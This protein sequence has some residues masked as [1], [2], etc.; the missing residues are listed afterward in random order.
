MALNKALAELSVWR[1]SFSNYSLKDESNSWISDYYPTL[2]LSST[3]SCYTCLRPKGKRFSLIIQCIFSFNI[4]I[5]NFCHLRYK[6]ALPQRIRRIRCIKIESLEVN[7]YLQMYC[8][9]LDRQHFWTYRKT[10]IHSKPY[11]R[12]HDYGGHFGIRSSIVDIPTKYYSLMLLNSLRAASKDGLVSCPSKL[13]H[14]IFY[15]I[16]NSLLSFFSFCRHLFSIF[17]L[18]F[19]GPRS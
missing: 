2:V 7:Q 11:A 12:R 9:V 18:L 5:E 10:F 4:N 16:L 1:K 3:F 15:S 13:S 6:T 14:F 17:F 8:L 19:F